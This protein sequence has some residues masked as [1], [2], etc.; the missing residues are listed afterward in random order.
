MTDKPSPQ[1]HFTAMA[2][3]ISRNVPTEFAG[4]FCIVAPDGSVLSHAFFD[5]AGDVASFWGF[6]NSSVQVAATQAIQKEE[7]AFGRQPGRR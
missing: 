5:P 6:I 7:L 1:D 4:A 3:R 2:E